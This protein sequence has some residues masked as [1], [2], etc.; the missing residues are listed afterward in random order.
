MSLPCMNRLLYWMLSAGSVSGQLHSNWWCCHDIGCPLLD[1]EHSLCTAPWSGTSCRTTS[2]HSRTMSPLDRA[3]KP[4]FSLDT[5][6]FS[7]LE[8]F[9]IIALYKL[10]FTIPY[11]FN[12]K[13]HLFQFTNY[14]HADCWVELTMEMEH[15]QWTV[16]VVL[17]AQCT[18]YRLVTAHCAHLAT[19]GLGH[20]CH[21]SKTTA[22]GGREGRHV[23]MITCSTQYSKLWWL[24][25]LCCRFGNQVIRW[26]YG[27]RP[28][29]KSICGS[30][31]SL[32]SLTG[33]TLCCWYLA[34]TRV[35]M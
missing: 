28:T 8:T 20:S 15:F 9:V 21:N 16:L 25:L 23:S 18:Q 3:W 4:G 33:P 1:A 2:A 29:W 14:Y 27:T 11:H 13:Y 7:A 35:K 30:T 31:H 34:C 19:T 5:S 17:Q 22:D 24:N 32:P 26:S 10:T 12:N 6:M